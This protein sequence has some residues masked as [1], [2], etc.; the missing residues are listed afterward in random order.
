MTT[1]SRA[2]SRAGLSDTKRAL[3]DQWLAGRQRMP[4]AGEPAPRPAGV[5]DIP[6][7]FAQERMWFL[8]QLDPGSPLYNVP[9][10]IWLRRE[11]DEHALEQSINGIVRRHEVL[12]TRFALRGDRPVQIVEPAAHIPLLVHDLRKISEPEQA[13]ELER[14][15]WKETRRLFDLASGPLLRATLVRLGSMGNADSPDSNTHVLLLV[16]HHI[17]ADGWSMA[18]FHRELSRLYRWYAEGIPDRLPEL[19][20]QYADYAIWQRSRLTSEMLDRQLAYWKRHL[21]GA[22][23]LLALPADF[24]RPPVQ[25]A[26]GASQALMIERD[27]AREIAE[28]GRLA[29]ATSFMTLLAALVVLLYR[30]SGQDDIVIGTPI[31]GRSNRNT[32]QLIGCF[33]NT[34]ALRT[35]VRAG[36]S[37]LAVL[38]DVREAALGGFA[39][40]DLPFERLLE[41][42]QPQRSTAWTPVFQVFLNMLNYA[43]ARVDLP[44]AELP[45][46]TLD[47]PA[48]AL[49]RFDLTIYAEETAEGLYLKAVYRTE[50]FSHARIGEMLAQYRLLLQ[51]VA[52][53]PSAPIE[54]HELVTLT[55][56]TLLP[57]PRQ[58]LPARPW[59][60]IHRLVT[61]HAANIPNQ[62]AL[63]DGVR[64]WTYGELRAESHALATRLLQLGIGPG[65]VVA[66]FGNRSPAHAIAILGVLEAGAAFVI[67]EPAYPAIRLIACLRLAKP[68]GWISLAA[69]GAGEAG[70]RLP[71]ELA[72][73]LDQQALKA[74]LSLPCDTGTGTGTSEQP[75]TPGM[76]ETHLC[77]DSLAYLAF[78]S[79]TTGVPRAIEGLH[80]PLSHFVDW[81]ITT[82]GLSAADRFSCVSGLSHDPF[83]RDVLTP[84][85]LGATLCIPGE[86]D[87]A[88][89][90]QFAEWVNHER[91]SVMHLTPAMGT[92][93]LD[94]VRAIAQARGKASLPS[95]RYLFF[96]G[97]VLD[98]AF[99]PALRPFAPNAEIVNFYGTTETPQAM[100]WYRARSDA[101]M[102]LIPFM[103]LGCGIDGAQLIIQS[104]PG[105][106][107]G[108]GELGQIHIRSPY[109]SRGY[110]DDPGLTAR[111]YAVN[112]FRPDGEA[113]S[114][115]MFQT[116]DLGR[117]LLDGDVVFVGRA[118]E[119]I[120]IRGFR[121]EAGEVVAAL[122][123]HPTVKQARI[124]LEQTHA[125]GRLI[126]YAVKRE[127]QES[128]I[129]AEADVLRF[130]RLRLPDHMIPAGIVWLERLPL[131]SNGKI[132][133][134]ALPAANREQRRTIHDTAPRT[135]TERI[136]CGIWSEVL[137]VAPIGTDDNFFDLG[138]HSLAAIRVLAAIMARLNLDLPLRRIFDAPTV[139]QLA[140]TIV[141]AQERDTQPPLAIE[142]LSRE[143]H[144]LRPS[145]MP[146]SLK[147][148]ETNVP[149]PTRRS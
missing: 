18:V 105:V 103:P 25:G 140:C 21:E 120:K 43:E 94:G 78:T 57:D 35:K 16:T 123:Q 92:I 133:R 137:G 76:P 34:M 66:I 81:H 19:P 139:A 111:L 119:Q 40:A 63:S 2:E 128:S 44:G 32:E 97:D 138:G 125:G 45:K 11:V 46:E 54:S 62:V 41:A 112:P 98:A 24:P 135:E 10:P 129:I 37:F 15:V 102:P 8:H 13:A 4:V 58:P 33:L 118:D 87:L 149:A 96:G 90:A 69:S 38:H 31:A 136:L 71:E 148:E 70:E 42:L 110:R 28:L 48:E 36:M 64:P 130:L 61:R 85:A 144:R 14:L 86:R 132:D 116:G 6:L 74:R 30:L 17:A 147:Q 12:R 115:R 9:M 72:S 29:R 65:E 141:A 80:A 122:E 77:P 84:L 126:A 124:L 26:E 79:G 99:I 50:L 39:H 145:S 53:A 106:Q 20:I 51:K 104:A 75:E 27:V 109:L 49:A 7:S 59:Q 47:G 107:A 143:Q 67:L 113:A 82:F 23:S 127:G 142:R 3:L 22:P 101:A 68:S 55:A 131:T 56:R 73:F 117:Y 93:L 100:A 121:V 89:A 146:T 95:L 108:I 88:S 134:R 1:S 60:A 52:A 5:S 91:I 114:D 83:L